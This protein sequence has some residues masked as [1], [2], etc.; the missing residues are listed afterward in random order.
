MWP[1][2]HRKPLLQPTLYDQKR[3]E[4]HVQMYDAMSTLEDATK[5][6]IVRL[7]V[8]NLY[9][10]GADKNKAQEDANK[11]QYVLLCAIGSYDGL[12]T[13]YIKYVQKHT[14]KF[15]TTANWPM[16]WAT[17]HEVIEKTY[18]KFF[19]ETP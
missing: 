1:F 8:V 4:M 15:V 17:S 3:H 14:D 16:K 18:T 13:D 7:G 12:R 11:Q 19:Q 5:A 6:T 2:T 10:E 9:P